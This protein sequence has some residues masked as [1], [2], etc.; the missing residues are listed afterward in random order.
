[1]DHKIFDSQNKLAHLF[2]R[3][4]IKVR[5]CEVDS[6]QIVWH[7]SYIKYLEDGRESFG[8]HFGIGYADVCSHGYSI[9]LVKLNCDYKLPL[10]YG[11]SAIVETRFVNSDAAKILFEYSVFRE[12]DGALA[13]EA[14]SM[15]VFLNQKNELELYAPDFFIE[16]KKKWNLA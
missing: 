16:W 8:K 13:M 3:Q 12:S 14:F 10:R 15:Q 1:M 9:P 4:I 2:D 7:G 5:F 11:D 6:M